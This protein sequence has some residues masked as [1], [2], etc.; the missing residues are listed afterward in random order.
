[1]D[2]VRHEAGIEED[3][4]ED[5]GHQQHALR[6][7]ELLEALRVLVREADTA[8]AQQHDERA[9]LVAAINHR[10]EVGEG[11]FR[12]HAAEAVVAAETE[13]HHARGGLE[14]LI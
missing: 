4:V 10:G 5:V 6:L 8:D 11:L 7:G 2:L 13:Q 3:A 12:R 14:G 1:M 9:G